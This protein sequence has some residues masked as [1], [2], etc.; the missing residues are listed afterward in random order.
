[1]DGRIVL[2]TCVRHPAS[3]A[4]AARLAFHGGATGL[5]EREE[6]RRKGEGGKRV[7][8]RLTGRPHLVAAPERVWLGGLVWLKGWA[9]HG[10]GKAR[11]T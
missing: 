3:A 2:K 6:E 4:M 9:A 11:W 10:P 5:R 1:V 8:W 7:R